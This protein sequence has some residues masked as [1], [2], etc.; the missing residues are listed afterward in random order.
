MYQDNKLKLYKE[1]QIILSE[2]KELPVIDFEKQKKLKNYID[3]LVFVLYFNVP[4]K[5]I[6][7]DKAGEIRKNCGEN[8][9][10][11]ILLS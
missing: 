4:V 8:K 2:L 9:F 1:D 7:M 5:K 10:Y 3:D 6:S 11:K